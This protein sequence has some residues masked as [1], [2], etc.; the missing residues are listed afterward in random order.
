MERNEGQK[1]KR[2]VNILISIRLYFSIAIIL[3]YI[4]QRQY[5]LIIPEPLSRKEYK[6][7]KVKLKDVYRKL[8]MDGKYQTFITEDCTFSYCNHVGMATA[9]RL[10]MWI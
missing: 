1:N 8:I 7:V 5:F 6:R 2:F 4:L 3:R 9:V 10:G